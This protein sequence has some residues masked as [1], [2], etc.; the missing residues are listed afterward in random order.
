MDKFIFKGKFKTS[1]K[2]LLIN[3]P[4]RFIFC[5]DAVWPSDWSDLYYVKIVNLCREALK[6]LSG[7]VLEKITYKEAEKLCKLNI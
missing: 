5:I 3:H 7:N 6:D 4:Y 2:R 1:W